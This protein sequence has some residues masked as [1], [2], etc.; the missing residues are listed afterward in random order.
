MPYDAEAYPRV[1]ITHSFSPYRIAAGKPVTWTVLTKATLR[2]RRQ[3]GALRLRRIVH[4]NLIA[5]DA[6]SCVNKT[7]SPQQEETGR[8]RRRLERADKSRCIVDIGVWRVS[9]RQAIPR[10]QAAVGID[11]GALEFRGTRVPAID[12]FSK[13]NLSKRW[14]NGVLQARLDCRVGICGPRADHSA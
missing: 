11:L 10:S 12:A 1:P 9:A 13:D 5:E 4:V 3:D 8:C 7:L 14:P 2:S 6:D